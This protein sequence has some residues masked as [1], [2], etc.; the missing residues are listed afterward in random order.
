MISQRQHP[1]TCFLQQAD[2]HLEP[3]QTV[4]QTHEPTSDISYS[5]H[6]E[7]LNVTDFHIR[8]VPKYIPFPLKPR[9]A[10]LPLNCL[11]CVLAT[12]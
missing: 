7:L 5:N 4:P 3:P 2:I 6:H 1:V 11:F 12:S 10:L 8:K 9:R